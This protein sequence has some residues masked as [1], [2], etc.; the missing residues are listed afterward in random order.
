[1]NP[2]LSKYPLP[3]EF[4]WI[5]YASEHAISI[6]YKPANKPQEIMGSRSEAWVINISGRWKCHTRASTRDS[7]TIKSFAPTLDEELQ[8]IYTWVMLGMNR[9]EE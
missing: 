4:E 5:T 6:A 9:S 1:M 8:Y 3:D 2:D 7:N